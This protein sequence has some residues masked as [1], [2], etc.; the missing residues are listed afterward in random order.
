MDTLKNISPVD[1]RYAIKTFEIKNYFSE[2]ALINARIKVECEYFI[3]LTNFLYKKRILKKCLSQKEIE[4]IRKIYLIPDENAKIVKKIETKGYQDIKPTNHD[5]KAVEYYLKKKL[6][7][8]VKYNLEFIHFGLTSEDVNNISYSIMIESYLKKIHI[9]NIDEIL[10]KLKFFIKNYYSTPFP[11]R[12]HGQLASPTTFGKEIRVFYERIHNKLIKVKKHKL[13][14]KIN[15][16]VGNYNSFVVAYPKIN[17]LSFSKEFITH[18]NKNLET[19]FETNLYTTQIEPH[20]SWVELFSDLSHLN[21]I[22]IGFCQDIWRYISDE[23]IILKKFDWEVGSSTMPHKVNPIDFENAEGNLQ[24]ANSNFNF[25]INK[26]P[27]SRMQ[28]DLT[29]STVERNFGVAFAHTI[30]AFK[31]IISGL[32]KITL[33]SQKALEIIEDEAQIY[34]EA[35]QTILRK[36]GIKNAYE[37]LKEFSRGKKISKKDIEIFIDK[38]KLNHNIKKELR[39]IIKTKYIG[40]ASKLALNNMKE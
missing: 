4:L 17:W 19:N 27:I 36:H 29:D 2:H 20:D 12:T 6:K 11:A 3:F 15:G 40:L 5:V 33:N 1:G 39:K 8:K 25:F 28:R 10:S 26:L 37:I 7:N 30:I 22:L 14:V 16:A 35:I 31:S 13:K 34:S 18:L 9:P 21:T 38:I 32:S 24:I 23:L